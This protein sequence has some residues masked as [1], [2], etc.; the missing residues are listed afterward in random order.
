M[1][2]S[3]EYKVLLKF[4]IKQV[5]VATTMCRS[6]LHKIERSVNKGLLHDVEETV[7]EISEQMKAIQKVLQLLGSAARSHAALL[8]VLHYAEK[9]GVVLSAAMPGGSAKSPNT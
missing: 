2:S 5:T 3:D 7:T 9:Q 6:L 4:N 1:G 8:E